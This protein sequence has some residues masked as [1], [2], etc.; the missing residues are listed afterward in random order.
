[1][2]EGTGIVHIAPA[3][4]E[5]DYLL[6][7][8][9][10]LEFLR[11]VDQA[12][13]FTAEFPLAAHEFVK[14]ADARIVEDLKER[15][16]LYRYELY[17]HEYP[18][19]WRCDTP[20]LYYAL[21]SYFIKTT[22]RQEEIIEN[23]RKIHW[24]P[25]YMGEGR[26][27]DFLRNMKDWA[28]S[29]NRYW[30]TPLPIWACEG[31]GHEL[32][33]GSRKELVELALDKG[34]AG[35][36]EPHRPFIDGVTLR[37]P[38]CGGEMHRV[39]YV[40]DAWFD[41]GMMHTAQ[42]HYPFENRERFK[43]Q[44]P[45][46]F[47]SE[48]QDQ[49][50]G[51][52]YTLLV[53]STLLH[54]REA[55]KNVVVTGYG[56]D[57]QGR[58]MSKSRGNVLDP[59]PLIEDYGADA[60]RWYLYSSS[61]PWKTRQLSPKGVGEALHGV[62]D[63]VK[64]I[65]NFFALYAGIDRFDPQEHELPPERRPLIDRWALSRLNSTV[66]EVTGALDNYDAVAATAAIEK[67][68][69]GL[70]N[71][72]V[73]SSRRR[74][75]GGGMAKEKVAAYLTL[76]HVLLELAKLLA[77][78]VPFLAESIYQGLRAEQMSESVHLCDWPTVDER[79]I[80]EELERRME[81]GRKVAALGRAARNSA[82]V[83]VRQP[84]RELSVSGS[85]VAELFAEPEIVALVRDELNIKALRAIDLEEARKEFF[86]PRVAPKMSALGPKFGPRA[87]QI[88]AKLGELD[89]A[90]AAARLEEGRLP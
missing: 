60:I 62:L 63:T 14:E 18:F 22:A 82:G 84:L 90:E 55:Y 10:G 56:L 49:T 32:A 89:P 73:R 12:G 74:F 65:Y 8:D 53:T 11:P 6:G 48:G 76:Y 77:P 17:E 87:P 27:G 57:E 40:I 59:W 88:A 21:D 7:Q 9:E 67:F 64:N 30:G 29:R 3:F 71:W 34:L 33:L 19:C 79:M 47:I 24:Y 61:A 23:N 41:S 45:A 35:E 5:E 36:V 75:W 39:P 54:G 70:S 80:D 86:A 72:Y 37:C 68:V 20:L 25:E 78:F 43:E 16:I 1:L 13:R 31:C 38:E 81:L 58:A 51:W 69:D 50:R 42:W 52:F 15:G 26:F 4:G 83:K 46:D 66:K 28:L 2:E 85:G 44:F